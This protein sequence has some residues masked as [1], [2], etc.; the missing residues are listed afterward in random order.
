MWHGW[1]YRVKDLAKKR[2]RA[3]GRIRKAIANRSRGRKK[4]ARTEERG[5]QRGGINIRARYVIIVITV[6]PGG[7]RGRPSVCTSFCNL[8]YQPRYMRVN[9]SVVFDLT[10][11]FFCFHIFHSPFLLHIDLFFPPYGIVN[12]VARAGDS[13]SANKW[14]N[15]WRIVRSRRKNRLGGQK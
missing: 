9:L 10:G 14:C 4:K 3:L 13:W 1:L 7:G 15:R 11:V 5:C 2:P 8:N 12:D 6:L